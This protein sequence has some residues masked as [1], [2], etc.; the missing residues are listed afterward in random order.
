MFGITRITLD[1]KL[2]AN[3]WYHYD[4]STGLIVLKGVF[5]ARKVNESLGTIRI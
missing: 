1:H 5:L 4:L 3:L 2:Q